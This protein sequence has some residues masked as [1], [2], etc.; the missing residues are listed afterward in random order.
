M[1]STSSHTEAPAKVNVFPP[2]Q[3]DTFAVQ[4]IWLGISFGLLYGLVAKIGLPRL[5]DIFEKRRA[6]IAFDL[7]AAT[8]NR[9]ESQQLLNACDNAI[10]HANS[11]AETLVAEARKRL[12]TELAQHRSAQAA[13][14]EQQ[15]KLAEKAIAQ[16]KASFTTSLPAVAG[17]AA[18]A[19]AVRLLGTAPSKDAVAGAVDRV[20][21]RAEN[22][23][24]S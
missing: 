20:M 21:R 3:S 17:E 22:A 8:R 2:F 24:P 18:S 15:V 12:N 6:Q 16:A 23:W 5:A 9:G 1:Q 13:E 10:S 4:L 11:G 14:L 7:A 19:I